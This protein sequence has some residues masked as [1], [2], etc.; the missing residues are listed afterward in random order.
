MIWVLVFGGIALAG[1]L[2]VIWYAVWLIHKASDVM[3]EVAVLLD[4]LSQLAAIVSEI[5]VPDVSGSD[6]V[7]DSRRT[8]RLDFGEELT[9]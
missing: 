3:S 8:V 5:R 1:L 6:D 9:T 7:T 2:M 4:R